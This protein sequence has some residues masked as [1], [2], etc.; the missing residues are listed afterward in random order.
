ML[1][2]YGKAVRQYRDARNVTLTTMAEHL[3]VPPSYLSAIEHGRKQP[4]SSV[5]ESTTEFFADAGGPSL[6]D[7]KSLANESPTHIKLNLA[8]ADEVERE[9]YL[10][11]GRGFRHLPRTVKEEIRQFIRTRLRH[12]EDV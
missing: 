6:A 4:S 10:A 1:T 11:V 8:A 2:P 3:G 9:V 5:I 12:Q 7:W